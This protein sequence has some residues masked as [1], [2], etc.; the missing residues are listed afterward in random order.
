MG[1]VEWE[2]TRSAYSLDEHEVG[3][4]KSTEE[5]ECDSERDTAFAMDCLLPW[6]K[7]LLNSGGRPTI[8]SF[9]AIR[10]LDTRAPGV[11]ACLAIKK[12][13]SG[14]IIAVRMEVGCA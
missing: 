3:A 13:K 12:D 9:E 4:A 10:W 11:Y 14:R 7:E 5:G 8:D 2:T 1:V 6:T